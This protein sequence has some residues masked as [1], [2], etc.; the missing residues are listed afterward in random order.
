MFGPCAQR[1]DGDD[2]LCPFSGPAP[3]ADDDAAAIVSEIC[4]SLWA[5][6]GAPPPQLLD[7]MEAT[8]ASTQSFNGTVQA[9]GATEA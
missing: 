4:P 7:S 1:P 8:T 6:S 3:A 9:V 5:H 2:L